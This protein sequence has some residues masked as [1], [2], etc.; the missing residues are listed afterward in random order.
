MIV[1]KFK[2]SGECVSLVQAPEDYQLQEGEEII[3][4]MAPLDQLHKAEYVNEAKLDKIRHKRNLLLRK[5]SSY[6]FGLS[7][8]AQVDTE[9]KAYLEA[10]LDITE[11]FKDGN[12]DAVEINDSSFDFPTD[13]FGNIDSVEL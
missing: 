2:S 6:V 7:A 8:G 13:P 10:L 1:A 3:E 5:H 12:G 4:T 11:Q 9:M